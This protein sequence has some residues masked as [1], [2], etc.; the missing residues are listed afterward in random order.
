M[1]LNADKYPRRKKRIKRTLKIKQNIKDYGVK[2]RD[3]WELKDGKEK[4]V[5]GRRGGGESGK[6]TESTFLELRLH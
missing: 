6:Q 1:R 5:H 2:K 4:D 3:E